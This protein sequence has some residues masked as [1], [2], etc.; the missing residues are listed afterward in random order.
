MSR[1]IYRILLVLVAV[2]AGL[3]LAVLIPRDADAPA[4]PTILIVTQTIPAQEP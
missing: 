3:L 1:W 2:V 4:G